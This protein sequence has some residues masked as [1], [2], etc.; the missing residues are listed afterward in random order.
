MYLSLKNYE[1]NRDLPT[2]YI[3]PKLKYL[4]LAYSS[5]DFPFTNQYFGS[6][7]NLYALT[8]ING[9]D[10]CFKELIRNSK[11]L[12][13]FVIAGR[14]YDCNFF[15]DVS[16]MDSKLEEFVF[17]NIVSSSKND[18]NL[19]Y[20]NDFFWSQGKTLKRFT[21]D[22]L[23]EP[24]E[25]ENAFKMPNLT[26]MCVK[27][28]H[29][30][31]ELMRIKLDHLRISPPIKPASLTHFVVDYMD[32]ILFEL[33]SICAPN[34]KEMLV[35]RFEVDEDQIASKHLLFRMLEILNIKHL[36]YA[37]RNYVIHKLEHTHFERLLLLAIE[38]V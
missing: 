32:N 17:N 35:Q 8:L 31:Q 36:S 5:S 22:A 30:N 15:K 9:C 38:E 29:Y 26:Q 25:M 6:T 28:F 20:F 18:E 12:T 3:F 1:Y 11:K 7:D 19:R 37:L 13:K 14:F 4:H 21:T 16:M 33:L 10:G 23:I 2:S 24:D 34:L 27:G